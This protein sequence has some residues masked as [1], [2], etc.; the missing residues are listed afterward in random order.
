MKQVRLGFPS[1]ASKLVKKQWR[2]VHE[3][4]SP[5]LHGSEPKDGQFDGVGYDD[6]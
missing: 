5:S 3:A 4:S 1:Y 2:V 6:V